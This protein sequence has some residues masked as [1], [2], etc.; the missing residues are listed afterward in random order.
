MPLGKVAQETVVAPDKDPAR[1]RR[2][3][4]NEHVVAVDE[5]RGAAQGGGF[6]GG[7]ADGFGEVG[8]A[9][10]AQQALPLP[11]RELETIADEGKGARK[12]VAPPE[13][14]AQ[15]AGRGAQHR[16]FLLREE[17]AI[18]RMRSVHG[19]HLLAPPPRRPLS[20]ALSTPS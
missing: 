7:P 5:Q 19:R 4:G 12:R 6:H 11:L 14:P 10:A 2:L 1:Q 8:R 18:L 15:V 20:Y 9:D 13:E 17:R 16:L 3:D